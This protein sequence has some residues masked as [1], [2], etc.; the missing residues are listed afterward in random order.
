M[1]PRLISLL[2]L[3]LLGTLHASASAQ[4]MIRISDDDIA[5]MGVVFNP[6]VR[7]GN[8]T[9]NRFPATVINSPD[10][11]TTLS[12]TVSGRI[13][14]WYLQAGEPV[15]AGTVLATVRSQEI[16]ALQNA[17]IEAVTALE[18]ADFLLSKDQTLFD[19]GVILPSILMAGGKSRVM[20]RSE[21]FFSTMSVSRSRMYLMA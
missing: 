2:S 20:N 1:T 4:D 6:V 14:R 10:T 5:R 15:T 12:S 8:D 11:A 21:P 13:D 17:W 3:T 7:S 18:S 19:T 9:G 16:L